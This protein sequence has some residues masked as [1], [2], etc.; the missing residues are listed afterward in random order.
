MIEIEQTK[1]DLHIGYVH[2]L[3][4]EYTAWAAT[5]HPLDDIPAF[6]GFSDE[7][8]KLPGIYAPPKGRL[9]LALDDGQPA[10]CVA[11]KPVRE[12]VAELKRMYVRPGNRGKGIG[13]R[14]GEKLVN[15][16][17]QIGNTKI[18]LDSH[19]SMTGAHAIYRKLGFKQVAPP[20]GTPDVVKE[21]AIFMELDLTCSKD[22]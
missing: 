14:L 4:K 13:W 15:E 18:I 17:R 6:E 10:G 7:I 11:L 16:A 8:E 22:N 20:A 12:G 1:S 5:L 19:H 2:E 3:L 9:L 21:L